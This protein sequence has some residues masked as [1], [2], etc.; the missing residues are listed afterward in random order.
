M[1]TGETRM[2]PTLVNPAHQLPAIG[3][4]DHVVFSV[5]RNETLRI[6]CFLQH[7]R[8]LGF[9]HFI[10]IA[11]DSDDD[12]AEFLMAQPDVTLFHTNES[13]RWSHSGI[14][15]INPIIG[16]CC[17]DSWILVV[18]CDELLV[19]PGSEH[20]SIKD[21]TTRLDDV[22]ARILFTVMLDMYSDKPF[23]SIG[24]VRGEPLLNATPFF[25]REPYGFR[26]HWHYPFRQ[27]YG[28]PRARTFHTL[29]EGHCNPPLI[30][31]M[32]LLRWHQGQEVS[33]GAHTVEAPVELAPMRG[34]LL[35]FKLLD[36]MPARCEEEV[37]RKQCWNDGSEYL[38]LGRAIEQAPNHSFFDPQCSVR[39]EGTRQLVALNIMHEKDPFGGLPDWT[40]PFLSE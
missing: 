26:P 20:E 6:P 2:P 1:K 7:Y 19:W 35:H 34:A 24:Y 5:V 36:D 38:A 4:N 3:P 17:V 29:Q 28:G 16:S 37:A 27:L 13:Y 21:L 15:W 22:Q 30:S 10:M 39:Y 33:G 18:D 14:T 12:T 8:A 40:G 32:P 25:D 11:H 9:D 31:K 23:G